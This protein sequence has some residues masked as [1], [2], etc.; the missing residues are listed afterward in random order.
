[1]GY[2]AGMNKN[3]KLYQERVEGLKWMAKYEKILTCKKIMGLILLF[4]GLLF[5]P[6]TALQAAEA[7]KPNIIVILADDLGYADLGCQGSR[8]IVS[9]HMDSM[10]VNGMRCTAGYIS[11]PQCCPSRAG[12]MTGRYQNRFGF[13][14]NDQAQLGGLPISEKTMADRLKAV[15]YVTGM[16]GKWHLGAGPNR[17]PYQRGFDDSFWHSNGGVLFPDK[18]TG[19]IDHLYRGAELLRE[20]EYST[21]AFGRE[22]VAFI[23]RHQHAPFFLYLALVPPHWPMESKPEH[24]AQFAHI[25]DLHRRTMLG[26]M[27]SL[28]ENVGRVLTKLRETKL[29]ENTLIFFLSDNGGATGS[30]RQQPDAA[31]EYGQNTSKN[32]PCRGVKGDL[33]EGGIRVPFIVQWK[34]RI[35]AGKTY[36]QPVISLDILPTALAAA[37]VVA[38]SDWK[39]DGTNL[40]PFFTGEKVTAPH[41]SLYW[42]F[43][44]P[45][46]QLSKHS[47]AIRQGD[48]KLVK[49]RTEPLSL[50]HLATDIGETRN[51]AAEQ[52]ER[53]A[54]LKKAYQAW[55][56]QNQEP[57]GLD[58][59]E[60]K[61]LMAASDHIQDGLHAKT[62][63]FPTEI[64]MECTAND[65]QLI[66]SGIPPAIT[67]PFTLELRVKSTSKGSGE[68][69]WSTSAK[70]QFSAQNSVKL[71]YQHSAAE[72]RD[73]SVN[74]PAVT[75]ALMHLR[76]DPGTAP[77]L[78]RI[79]RFVL[80]DAKGKVIKA[81]VGA[82]A[83]T[84]R[85]SGLRADRCQLAAYY[86]PNW[87]PI[88]HSEWNSLKV[89]R[90]RFEGHTQPKVPM[91]GYEN[92][93]DPTVMARKIAAAADHGLDAF[94]FDWYY[95]DADDSRAAKSL[96]YSQDG[97]R[98]LHTA[99]ESG[100]LGAANKD[101]LKFAI[102]WCNHDMYPNAKGVVKPETFD[103]M[104]DYVIE[105][106]FKHP[107]Y[108]KIDGSPYFSIYDFNTF[109]QVFGGD[110]SK[111]AL[112][113]ARFRDKVRAAGLPDL[114]LNAVLFGLGGRE[115]PAIVKSLSINSVTTYTWIHH[116][117]LSGFPKTD[118]ATAEK[119]YFDAVTAGSGWNGLEQ[120]TSALAVPYHV[121]VSM[122]WDSSPRCPKE[123]DWINIKYGYPFGPV[124]VN[125][126]PQRFRD[127]LQRAKQITIKSPPNSRIITINSWN[128]WGEGSYLEPDT[129]HGMGYLEAIKEVFGL[130]SASI[131][132][133]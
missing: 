86:F 79:A 100:Y 32:D 12:L 98:Y 36:D 73:E 28:D 131:Q 51:L 103:R 19:V 80:K 57:F 132:H 34:G 41:D 46:A 114:H 67:G 119:G 4:A 78:V 22:A 121:N 105:K 56:A 109:L 69:F 5:D 15:G 126:T 31:F 7:R 35:P 85:F 113:L 104:T 87:G 88:P 9:P 10:A 74:L 66:L 13:E 29:E 62:K 84:A 42:R 97:S 125:N 50:Y 37:G 60:P 20:K 82:D 8:E 61:A 116:F 123:A 99:L 6:L 91:W 93:Q 75:P 128:E 14:T 90:P 89:A 124:I 133:E 54:S 38:P 17:Q 43:R 106:Y 71:S 92:E 55:D 47:W 30:P 63:V 72:W 108:W 115:S 95:Y 107:C 120:P 70:P 2:P 45:P 39:L 25:P 27:A 111:A 76:F 44:F 77:G 83:A 58:T 1:M 49:N 129:I 48:W 117:P 96:H 21:D 101:R 64:R 23:D 110:R 16:V 122:G 102:M 3:I 59:P 26:M 52:S 94:I 68:I 11:A 130:P 65:P 127:A 53:V 24:L 40:L 112:A 81:W 18:K 118:Y 33:L